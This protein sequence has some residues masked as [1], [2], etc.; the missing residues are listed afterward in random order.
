MPPACRRNSAAAAKTAPHP[1][2]RKFL[3]SRA[4]AFTS[5][6]PY[7]YDDSDYDWIALQ[8]DWEV[9][10]GPYEV[11]KNPRQL[12]ALFEMY[13]GR[14]DKKL[15]ADLV[16]FKENLQEMENS[17]GGLVGK[18]VYQSRKLDP[19]ISLRVADIWMAS[20]DGRRDRR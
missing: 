20:G 2:L 6:D 12:K 7:P 9:T 5:D 18:D 17:L 19:R 11:Y 15:T 4:A 1:S 13:I 3:E 16:R 14:E 8:G 10:V